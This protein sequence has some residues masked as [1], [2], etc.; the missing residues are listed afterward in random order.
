MLVVL[1]ALLRFAQR[2]AF[3]S[4]ERLLG[5]LGELLDAVGS[6]GCLLCLCVV[7]AGRGTA[8]FALVLELLI[9]VTIVL[10]GLLHAPAGQHTMC[11]NLGRERIPAQLA[12]AV[13][14]AIFG[15]LTNVSPATTLSRLS[16]PR[17][18]LDGDG[19]VW[20]RRISPPRALLLIPRLV[21][22][23]ATRVR[24]AKQGG[25]EAASLRE[26]THGNA[27]LRR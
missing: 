15:G 6:F 9:C 22:W 17:I 26:E 1:A 20:T 5:L 10:F 25:F 14:S 19:N 13:A 23:Q 11:H 16:G 24:N 27:S 12:P 8:S 21:G 4:L 3:G 2:F 18:A 7:L